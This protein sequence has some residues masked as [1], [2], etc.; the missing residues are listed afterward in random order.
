M[1]NLNSDIHQLKM[2]FQVQKIFQISLNLYKSRDNSQP[3]LASSPLPREESG[4][5]TKCILVNFVGG[6][7]AI[8]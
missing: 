7:A 6:G 5:E 1:A 4:L 8:G 3:V 2:L